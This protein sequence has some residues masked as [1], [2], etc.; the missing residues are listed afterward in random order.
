MLAHA[1]LVTAGTVLLMIAM[2]LAPAAYVNSVRRLASVF[3]VL[4]GHTM[5]AEPGLRQP[6][7]GRA[8]GQPRRRLP[9]H[10]ALSAAAAVLTFR[11]SDL[12]IRLHEGAHVAHH[13]GSHRHIVCRFLA[14]D[15]RT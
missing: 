12:E 14:A 3:S 1:A 7:H 15:G 11:S 2:T 6:P 9:A 13:G 5:F 4:L 8:P 10:G